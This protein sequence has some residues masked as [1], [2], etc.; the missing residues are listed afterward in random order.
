MRTTDLVDLFE[1]AGLQVV[2]EDTAFFSKVLA[3][4][5]PA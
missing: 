2:H 5:K 4:E 3:F 1:G